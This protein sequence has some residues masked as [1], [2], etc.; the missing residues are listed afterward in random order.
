MQR[1][2]ET[3]LEFKTRKAARKALGLTTYKIQA[4]S[5]AKFE[6]RLNFDLLRK[7]RVKQSNSVKLAGALSTP[8]KNTAFSVYKLQQPPAGTSIASTS[9]VLQAAPSTPHDIGAWH[10]S[11]KAKF[12]NLTRDDVEALELAANHTNAVADKEVDPG[13]LDAIQA[14]K[15]KSLHKTVSDTLHSWSVQTDF[16]GYFVM[17]GPCEDGTICVFT[18][19]ETF[20]QYMCSR[21]QIDE[22]RWQTEMELYFQNVF[23]HRPKPA[24]AMA[25][26]LGPLL[27]LQRGSGAPCIGKEI[28]GVVLNNILASTANQP[29]D[30]ITNDEAAATAEQ[31]PT[32]ITD[33]G[34]SSENVQQS[35]NAQ[36]RSS[37][38]QPV[39]TTPSQKC[40]ERSLPPIPSGIDRASD[41]SPPS[42]ETTEEISAM[43]IELTPG[44]GVVEPP[45]GPS[46][47]AGSAQRLSP[48]LP[49][50]R[51]RRRRSTLTA[52]RVKKSRPAEVALENGD[53][54]KQVARK[55]EAQ[56]HPV[57]TVRRSTRPVK[58][59]VA[60]TADYDR[61]AEGPQS[62]SVQK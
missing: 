12:A 32:T 53:K 8:Q 14:K 38:L 20:S 29:R 37:N 26:G 4:E 52:D 11:V 41:L 33:V 27:P 25:T 1:V 47:D 15:R 6:E 62:F 36:G 54:G 59:R 10:S 34:N 49:R 22:Q 35:F 13:F 21:F 24:K 2:E 30:Q 56:P 18:Y 55:R 61:V 3:K 31:E 7:N 23:R 51:R 60:G 28:L 17:G 5:D 46:A 43:D 57:T 39:A 50:N 48:E 9:Q 40:S 42:S 19:R 44:D 58:A 16:R 45:M